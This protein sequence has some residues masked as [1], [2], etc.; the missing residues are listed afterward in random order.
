MKK[1]RKIKSTIAIIVFISTV[2]CYFLLQN[3]FIYTHTLG[4]VSYNYQHLG[5]DNNHVISPV[6]KPYEKLTQKNM[7]RW[8]ALLYQTIKDSSYVS[9]EFYNNE[10]YAFYPLFPMVWK[11]SCINNAWIFIFCYALFII[12]IILMSEYLD[13]KNEESYFTF[14]IALLSPSAVLFYLPYAECL[15]ILTFAIAILGLFKQKYWLF[16]LGALLFTLTRPASLIFAFALL[17]VDIRYLIAHRNVGYFIKQLTL[18][19]LP[20][21]IGFSLVTFMQYLYS[22][23]WTA[24]SDALL[25]WPSE[26]GYFNKI[27]DWSIEGFG[28]TAF[29]IFFLSFPCLLYSLIWGVKAFSKRSRITTPISLFK[30]DADWIKEYVFNASIA[31]TAGNIVYTFLTAGGSINGF[32]RYT[33]CVPTFYVILFMLQSVI[34]HKLLW[35]KLLLFT[36]CFIAMVISF[37]FIV[38]GSGR[39]RFAYSGLYLL[40]LFLIYS[41]IQQ[42]LSYKIRWIV[43][44]CIGICAI[45]WHTYLFNMYITDAWLFT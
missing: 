2:C 35:H 25:F 24:Y 37:Y 12:G 13:E 8:D 45:V 14:A 4:K 23:S 18:K 5:T 33:M 15:F 41:L 3:N 6:K 9:N 17:A 1:T 10:R 38:Y 19:I 7:Y 28:M 44:I 31:F 42:Q 30:G 26:S 20:F 43:L 27:V 11:A 22:G 32:Y 16:F 21:A 40:I 39:F 36:V 29:A 34:K